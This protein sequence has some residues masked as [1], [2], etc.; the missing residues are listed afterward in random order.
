MPSA[1]IL[2]SFATESGEDAYEK[3]QGG[4]MHQNFM[5]RAFGEGAAYYYSSRGTHPRWSNQVVAWSQ[6]ELVKYNVGIISAGE[7]DNAQHFRPPFCT[8]HG[9]EET[10]CRIICIFAPQ[11]TLYKEEYDYNNY[12]NYTA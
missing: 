12:T 3:G 8:F 2:R 9:K 4:L 5:P 7:G 10:V 1:G 11:I 6:L